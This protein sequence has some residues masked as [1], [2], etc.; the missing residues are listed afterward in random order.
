MISEDKFIELFPQ[1]PE[2]YDLLTTVPE[3]EADLIKYYLPSKL[4]RLN[5]LYTIIDKTGNK[6]PFRM[7]AAQF[8]VYA[9]MLRHPRLIILKS[10]QQGIST[11]YLL[12]FFDDALFR[13]DLNIGLMSQGRDESST[14]LE[15]VKLA[16]DELNPDIKQFLGIRKIKDNSNEFAFSNNS[17]IFIRTSFRSATLQRLHISEYGK[18]CN[19]S[20]KKAKETKTGTLQTLAAGNAGAIES[21]AEGVNDFKHM[22]D[23][24]SKL[25]ASGR[26][27]AA[28]DFYPVFLSWVDDPSCVENESQIYTDEA[29]N[30]FE[31]L[32]K[33]GIKLTAQQKNF[34][35]AQYRELGGDIY[36]EYPATEE[37]A[38]RAS[39]DGTYW[40]RLYVHHI[41]RA[42]RRVSK[43]FDRNL[44]VYASVDSGM[45]DYFVFCFFQ[46]WRGEIR[47]IGEFWHNN[48]GLDY[49]AQYLL[50]EIPKT[51]R[52]ETIFLPHDFA[53]RDMSGRGKTRQ[54]IF[55]E[56]GISN[57]EILDKEGLEKSIEL[58]RQQIPHTW[59]D[60]DCE[61][62]E[63]CYLNYSKEWDPKLQKWKDSP[64]DTIYRHGAD[65]IRYMYQAIDAHLRKSAVSHSSDVRDNIAL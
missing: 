44:P 34:W 6:I 41:V 5:N 51:W 21:T 57:T 19:E 45:H 17:T 36:Q 64:A 11:F 4:W 47:I 55:A 15:R 37:E 62:L 13:R 29:I 35:I 22:W 27:F 1:A 56:E 16:W 52:L 14:L 2:L 24:S 28:K 32:E 46:Y 12:N 10:R 38:F 9:A 3:C 23:A 7:N 58:A 39:K 43:L 49:Y 33:R 61:Y 20:P 42:S 8:K 30:Y 53:V 18:I 31:Y 59:I 60:E 48:Q 40:S 63:S 25:L 26:A 65:S 50:N 54:Q